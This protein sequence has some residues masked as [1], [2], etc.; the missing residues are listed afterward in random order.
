MGIT[1]S[2]GGLSLNKF[3]FRPGTAC[4]GTMARL[5]APK[6]VS[7]PSGPPTR[8]ESENPPSSGFFPP[9][10][11]LQPAKAKRVP[12]LS[13]ATPTRTVPPSTIGKG[14]GRRIPP[15]AVAWFSPQ[16]EL[17]V[18]CSA[19]RGRRILSTT[20][21]KFGSCFAAW[22]G[23]G[24]FCFFSSSGCG[25]APRA[26]DSGPFPP[27]PLGYA[28]SCRHMASQRRFRP[29][30]ESRIFNRFFLWHD[31]GPGAKLSCQSGFLMETTL[32][33]VMRPR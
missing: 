29:L 31:V 12:Y 11:R 14:G 33:F 21:L 13:H 25:T 1:K 28:V 17:S 23:I 10:R 8:A 26:T 6:L 20:T 24:T 4:G 15:A 18:T 16:R 22:N 32:Q 3:L 30:R 9:A 7:S 5:P 27:L 19:A 2:P